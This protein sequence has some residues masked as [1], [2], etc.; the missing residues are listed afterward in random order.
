M[1]EQQRIRVY[2]DW[3]AETYGPDA[4]WVCAQLAE[5]AAEQAW[6]SVWRPAHERL[7]QACLAH[8]WQP[9]GPQL[10][11]DRV[12]LAAPRA[13]G[14][15]SPS[16]RLWLSCRGWS[17]P[18]SLGQALQRD[19]AHWYPWGE[20]IAMDDVR[21][22]A[23]LAGWL[24]QLRGRLGRALHREPY[25]E[26]RSAMQ[27]LAR[28]VIVAD[29]QANRLTGRRLVLVYPL[30]DG[31][32]ADVVEEVARVIAAA[33]RAGHLHRPGLEDCLA[34][35]ALRAAARRQARETGDPMLDVIA[36]G[37]WGA[38]S[39][40]DEFAE[41][42]ARHPQ[43]GEALRWAVQLLGPRIRRLARQLSAELGR[44]LATPRPR[45]RRTRPCD[46]VAP[47][48]R[49]LAGRQPYAVEQAL[50]CV[51]ELP[52]AT[53]RGLGAIDRPQL[54]GWV[55]AL[56]RGPRHRALTAPLREE[57]AGWPREVP[58]AGWP[59]VVLRVRV[60]GRRKRTPLTLRGL[61]WCE[62]G[63]LELSVAGLALDQRASRTKSRTSSLEP[64][65]S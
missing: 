9:Y 55:E 65:A 7:V 60:A 24:H 58:I 39:L 8:P 40:G 6:A 30:A 48:A 16:R 10:S 19:I 49:V 41:R 14:W 57:R 23:P 17:P 1:N 3:L 38:S 20:C 47:I 12:R 50:L 51:G 28:A 25:A 62:P 33:M 63:R 43:G 29:R 52:V 64:S 34:D 5:V 18:G 45:R 59:P 61:R 53:L 31:L 37:R 56:E 32:A 13:L 27:A 36:A 11:A 2:R 42:L 22:S 4:A 54:R 35:P 46:G 21:S 15:S 26:V 44:R